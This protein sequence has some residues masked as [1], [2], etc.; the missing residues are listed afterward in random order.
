LAPVFRFAVSSPLSLH[1]GIAWAKIDQGCCFDSK[2]SSRNM[3]SRLG[4]HSSTLRVNNP[5][6]PLKLLLRYDTLALHGYA[7]WPKPDI[8]LH[9]ATWCWYQH[10]TFPSMTSSPGPWW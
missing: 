9:L 10:M 6:R 4:R 2:L 3:L 7:T 1:M 5:T 8:Y